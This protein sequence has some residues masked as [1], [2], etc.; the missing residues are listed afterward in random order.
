MEL[1]ARHTLPT[2]APHLCELSRAC[3]GSVRCLSIK[4]HA[5]PLG[6]VREAL[7]VGVE[8]KASRHRDS[9]FS[10]VGRHEVRLA[11]GYQQ[12]PTPTSL[13]RV[14]VNWVCVR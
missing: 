12:Q 7:Q 6:V 8:W 11:L 5:V 4:S 13:H 10:R 9:D 14:V 1:S 2:R 3:I